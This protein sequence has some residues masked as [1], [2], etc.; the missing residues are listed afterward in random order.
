[1]IFDKL[2]AAKPTELSIFGSLLLDNNIYLS[3]YIHLDQYRNLLAGNYY[4]KDTQHNTY[5]IINPFEFHA[6]RQLVQNHITL[7]SYITIKDS[8]GN[9]FGGQ[10][11]R[12]NFDEYAIQCIIGRHL[13]LHEYLEM[14]KSPNIS[15][16][17]KLIEC[18]TNF[19]YDSPV[20]NS[21]LIEFVCQNQP[22]DF[23]DMIDMFI[24]GLDQDQ[25]YQLLIPEISHRC[26]RTIEMA[27]RNSC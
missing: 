12:I 1:M 11:P 7:P 16:L 6:I 20:Y 17:H 8:V 14:I 22:K 13:H 15:S 26:S 18:V 23:N 21:K 4:L 3:P 9:I 24:S 2:Y 25:M 19:G 10:D 5:L 27:S